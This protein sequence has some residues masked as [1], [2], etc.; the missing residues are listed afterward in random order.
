M[1]HL[2]K[3]EAHVD[4][5]SQPD[6]AVGQPKAEEVQEKK[7][8]SLAAFLKEKNATS[9]QRQKFLATSVWLHDHRNLKRV[10]TGEVSKVLKEN[11][12]TS[13]RNA[14]QSLN[15]NVKQGFAEKDG[16]SFYITDEGRAELAK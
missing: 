9:N 13:L 14:S 15:D 8:I 16:K 12:Q 7:S 5:E 11:S 4:E 3:D 2:D 1:P 6:L 10:T